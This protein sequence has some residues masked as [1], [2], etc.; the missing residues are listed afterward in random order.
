MAP[1]LENIW[2]NLKELA[3]KATVNLIVHFRRSKHTHTQKP[4]NKLREKE[5][6]PRPPGQKGAGLHPFLPVPQTVKKNP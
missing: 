3:R 1:I 6:F 4:K 5:A 2:E